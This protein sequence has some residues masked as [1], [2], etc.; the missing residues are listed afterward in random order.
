M[1]KERRDKLMWIQKVVGGLWKRKRTFS[2][3]NGFCWEW[4]ETRLDLVSPKF[5]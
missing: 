1:E 4:A 2:G 5:V 3:I